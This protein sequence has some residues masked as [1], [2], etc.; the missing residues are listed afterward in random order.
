MKIYSSSAAVFNFLFGISG[1]QTELV[2][3]ASRGEVD[4]PVQLLDGS[5]EVGGQAAEVAAVQWRML[6]A[7]RSATGG[8]WL[9]QMVN[10]VLTLI[11]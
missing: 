9:G 3:A 10:N 5:E 7:E 11:K 8:H 6:G 1:D 2:E 4:Q